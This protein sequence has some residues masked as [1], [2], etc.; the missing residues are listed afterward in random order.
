[1]SQNT[2][3]VGTYNR[4]LF[5]SNDFVFRWKVINNGLSTFGVNALLING[6]DFLVGTDDGVFMSIDQ[7]A[8]WSLKGLGGKQITALVVDGSSFLQQLMD[9][10]F[11]FRRIVAILGMR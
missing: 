2:I 6:T 10:E 8:S 5:L 9:M 4:G 7:G 1:M 11:I 3:L